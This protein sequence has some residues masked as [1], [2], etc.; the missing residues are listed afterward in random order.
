LVLL[1]KGT[2]SFG[3]SLAI[4]CVLSAL[5]V[6]LKELS[7]PVFNFMKTVTNHHWVTHSLFDLI[8]FA[9]LGWSLAKVNGGAGLRISTKSFIQIIVG[10]I[11]ISV[12]VISGFYLIVG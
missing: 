9:V 11:V 10:A 5:L 3:V 7:E 8:V 12:V 4:A 2:V 6:I 1:K